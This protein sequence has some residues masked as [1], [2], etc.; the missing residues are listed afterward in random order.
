MS[1]F[2]LFVVA[3][4]AGCYQLGAYNALHPGESK[5]FLRLLTQRVWKWLHQ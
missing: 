5:A 2:T 1:V 3:C 4:C